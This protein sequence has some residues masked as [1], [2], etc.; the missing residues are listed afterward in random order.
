MLGTSGGPN[1]SG[2]EESLFK[3]RWRLVGIRSAA[4]GEY[5]ARDE[6]FSKVQDRAGAKTLKGPPRAF[7]AVTRMERT[8]TGEGR[9]KL[10][11]AGGRAI[12][13]QARKAR[14]RR[15]GEGPVKAF[16]REP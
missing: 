3:E 16:A 6:T 4:R 13:R 8:G 15:S 11:G 10:W 14:E 7:R 12:R 2:R 1:N 5:I 9:W